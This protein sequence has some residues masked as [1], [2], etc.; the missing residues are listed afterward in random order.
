MQVV[1]VYLGYVLAFV[2]HDFCIVC[3][4]TYILNIFIFLQIVVD[5]TKAEVVPAEEIAYSTKKYT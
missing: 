2:L 5:L 3:V 4:T 1:S